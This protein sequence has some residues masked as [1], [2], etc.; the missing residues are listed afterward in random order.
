MQAESPCRSAY[1]SLPLAPQ[2][3]HL[4]S[5]GA[6]TQPGGH[7]LQLVFRGLGVEPLG[8]EAKPVPL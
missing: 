6:A 5:P 7:A 1:S 3:L 2:S 4:I 8:H